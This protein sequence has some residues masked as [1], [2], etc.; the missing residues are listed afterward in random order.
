MTAE[1]TD[2]DVGGQL[3]AGRHD[4]TRI[5]HGSSPSAGTG[6]AALQIR[7]DHDLRVGDLLARRPRRPWSRRQMP[8]KLRSKFAIQDQLIAGLDRL[9]EARLV[10]AH[11]V[12]ARVL[13][14]QHIGA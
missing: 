2:L 3:R 12:E 5:D 11:E 10:D 14:R 6:A 1:G 9:A 13:I 4:R 7:R 8:L